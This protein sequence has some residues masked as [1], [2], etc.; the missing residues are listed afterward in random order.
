MPVALIARTGDD[1]A[2]DLAL[3]GL[4]GVDLRVARDPK[5]PTGTCIVLVAP[6]G[7]R[8]MLPDPG[9]NAALASTAA[10]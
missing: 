10:L 6:G 4:D 9:A 5:R 2:A 7:E 1:S 3:K 8:T